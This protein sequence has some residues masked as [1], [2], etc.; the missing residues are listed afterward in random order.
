[1]CGAVACLIR[2][3]SVTRAAFLFPCLTFAFHFSTMQATEKKK[4]FGEEYIGFL[5][6][7][8]VTYYEKYLFEWYD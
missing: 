1:V 8:E 5:K 4:T 3:L 7:F 6:R 2:R